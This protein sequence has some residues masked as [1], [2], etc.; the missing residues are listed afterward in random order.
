MHHYHH[1]IHIDD[2]IDRNKPIVFFECDIHTSFYSLILVIFKQFLFGLTLYFFFQKKLVFYTHKISSD[3]KHKLIE[4]D[5]YWEILRLFSCAR[6]LHYYQFDLLL[7]MHTCIFYCER[8]IWLGSSGLETICLFVNFLFKFNDNELAKKSTDSVVW[9]CVC[10]CVCRNTIQWVS[11]CCLH[12]Y[13]F[14]FCYYYF[15]WDNLYMENY[16]YVIGIVKFKTASLA[17]CRFEFFILIC[18]MSRLMLEALF[19]LIQTRLM[20]DQISFYHS[21]VLSLDRIFS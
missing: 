13:V 2:H 16:V 8:I 12:C 11:K 10:V 18:L 21:F 20:C 5:F 3:Y 4:I 7:D 17:N 14:S 19:Y 15:E 6:S 1:L 9:L